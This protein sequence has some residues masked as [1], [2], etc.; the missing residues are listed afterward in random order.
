MSQDFTDGFV[1]GATRQP[2]ERGRGRDYYK[3]Y[4]RGCRGCEDA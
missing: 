4:H 1:D 3:G 2:V